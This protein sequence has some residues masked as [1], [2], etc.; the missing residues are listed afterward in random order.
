MEYSEL[1]SRSFGLRLTPEGLLYDKVPETTRIGFFNLIFSLLPDPSISYP[2]YKSLYLE[3]CRILK[4]KL[5]WGMI[6]EPQFAHSIESI[7]LKCEWHTFYEICQI[8][9]SFFLKESES[10]VSTF[11]KPGAL[12]IFQEQTSSLLKDEFLGFELNDGKI[13]KIGNAITDAKIKEAR[14]LLKEPEFKGADQHFEKAI[15]F[16]NIR[17]NPDTE[18]C[19]KDAVGA[20]ES[21]GRIITSNEKAE[22]DNIISEAVKKGVIPKPLDQTFIKL[23]AY[24]GNEPGVAHGAV[25]ELKN[26]VDEAELV[27]AMSAAMIV[28][29]VKKRILLSKTS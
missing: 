19:I 24:R 28:Y 12:K 11:S 9:Y 4:I 10:P 3:L 25:G 8:V 2:C 14:I 21:V 26:K 20:I 16:F 13:V 15:Q 18:N 1:F 7:I 6:N 29:L 27:L 5:D 23:N 17:P 22:L